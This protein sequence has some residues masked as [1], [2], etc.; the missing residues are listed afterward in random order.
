MRH[1]EYKTRLYRIW[2]DMKSRC[3]YTGN[4]AYKVYVGRGIMVCDDWKN[5]FV[6]FRDWAVNNGYTDELTLD[7]IDNNDG[8]RPENCR[9]VSRS[10]QAHNLRAGKR[11][12]YGVAG[13]DQ[14]PGGKYRAAITSNY[15]RIHLG[16]FNTLDE[17]IRARKEA[18][19]KYW[20]GCN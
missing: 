10:V 16:S 8:Y 3:Y 4:T 18:E 9:W 13:I 1:G 17:A 20:G 2:A 5:D 11:S 19:K 6:K 15:R 12:Q 7:R 14:L